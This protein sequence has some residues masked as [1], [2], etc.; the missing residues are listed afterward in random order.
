[1]DPFLDLLAGW[2]VILSQVKMCIYSYFV[3]VS[4]A[5]ISACEFL[6]STEAQRYH[7][8]FRVPGI[9]FLLAEY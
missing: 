6:L 5:I 3:S 1:M 7:D 2:Y 4:S 8:S 9:Q